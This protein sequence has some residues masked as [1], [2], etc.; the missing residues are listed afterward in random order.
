MKSYSVYY[1]HLFDMSCKFPLL[2][3]IPRVRVGYEMVDSQR[4]TLCRVGYN[5]LISNKRKWNKCFIKSANKISRILSDCIC[6]NN[7][8][9]ACFNFEQ[10]HTAT[11]FGEHGIMAHIP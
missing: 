6:K 5:H 1:E 4:G 3:I 7:H 11:I 2:T 10:T 8:F 9:S